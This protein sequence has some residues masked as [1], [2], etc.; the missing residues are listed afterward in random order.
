MRTRTRTS[1]VAAVALLTF[2]AAPS[3]SAQV[4]RSDERSAPA[5]AGAVPI[6]RVISAVA[7]RTG[8]K[9]IVDPRVRGDVTMVGQEPTN[10]DYPTLLSILQVH[11]FAAIEQGGY[12][13]VIPDANIR[14]QALPVLSGKES[15]A[16]GEY[17]NKIITLKNVP[18][19]QLVP[20]LRP[21]L[22]QVAHLVAMPCKNALLVTDV[23]ASV[24]RIEKIARALDVGEPYTPPSCSAEWPPKQGS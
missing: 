2:A 6:E 3:A 20:I 17:V 10:V 5:M 7:K 12:V 23:Y 14:Q 21:L 4:E 11:G 18:A 13:R 1:I 9:F 22:P 16:E 8:K 19:V 15:H 24:Q